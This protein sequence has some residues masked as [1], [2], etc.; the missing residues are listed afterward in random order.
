LN[1][2]EGYRPDEKDDDDWP[3][4]M[5]NEENKRNWQRKMFI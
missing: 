5:K 1:R 4:M 2:Q 3:S